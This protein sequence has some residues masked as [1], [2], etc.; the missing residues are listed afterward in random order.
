[1]VNRKTALL[2]FSEDIEEAFQLWCD[3]NHK[4]ISSFLVQV[5]P[6][7]GME[8]ALYVVP[9]E[10]YGNNTKL[11]WREAILVST[12]DLSKALDLLIRQRHLEIENG[13]W[14][15]ITY[16]GNNVECAAIPKGQQIPGS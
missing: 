6:R 3:V 15:R 16:S 7:I 4:H 8:P 10:P 11:V 2:F 13:Y 9:T 14:L 12:E 1:M 5:R